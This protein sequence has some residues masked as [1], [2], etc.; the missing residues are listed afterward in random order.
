MNSNRTPPHEVP[1]RP[2]SS[3]ER[4]PCPGTATAKVVPFPL[5][6][7]RRDWQQGR[8]DNAETDLTKT[9]ADALGQH[10]AKGN[11]SALAI[12]RIAEFPVFA[13]NFGQHTGQRLSQLFQRRLRQDLHDGDLLESLGEDEF[14]L[15]LRGV[16]ELD[17]VAAILERFMDRV[18]GFYRLE[19]LRFHINAGA[20]VA[21]YPADA[22]TPEE[23]LR[24][25]RVAL[26][27]ANPFGQPT[28]QLFSPKI[29]EQAQHCMSIATEVQQA[30]VN[31]RLVLHYQPQ[32]VLASHRVVAAEALLRFEDEN[33]CLVPPTRFIPI[34]EERRL[35]VAVGHWVIQEACR[36]LRRWPRVALATANA[37]AL[38]Y[39]AAQF[40]VAACIFL[41]HELR[42]PFAAG[43]QPRPPAC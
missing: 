18:T 21:L 41:F 42:T 22:N 29:L 7:P 14:A 11:V 20:G 10:R 13:E 4:D 30:L 9:L 36:Q 12:V 34:I 26:R 43:S 16:S 31:D 27:R 33:G 23:L 15:L 17:A 32:Y 19:G 6:R 25:A 24:Y 39:P 35:I 38:P 1:I 37:E 28:F 40:D 3:T 2:V 8:P 5:D